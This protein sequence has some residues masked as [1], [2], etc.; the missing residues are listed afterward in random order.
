MTI[1]TQHNSISEPSEFEES[2]FS[3]K[4]FEA[5][6]ETQTQRSSFYIGTEPPELKISRDENNEHNDDSRDTADSLKSKRDISKPLTLDLSAINNK[7]V[8]WKRTHMRSPSSPTFPTSP[9]ARSGY[10]NLNP[11]TPTYAKTRHFVQ[12]PVEQ[13][14]NVAFKSNPK[15]SPYYA[16]ESVLRQLPPIYLVACKLDPMLDD[17]IMFAKRLRWLGI[18][19]HVDA[20][21]DLPHGF[22]NFVLVSQDA[23]NGSEVCV[24]RL[25]EIL[26][27]DEEI[28]VFPDLS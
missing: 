6:K 13:F 1:A 28:T 27:L 14:R 16:P 23:W 5:K 18:E 9:L 11:T 12:S 24:A 2:R 3:A 26:A 15:M 25:K 10:S 19:V 20:L 22:L 4:S 17:S 8:D 21:E 7:P